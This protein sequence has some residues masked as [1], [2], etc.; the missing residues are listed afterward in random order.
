MIVLARDLMGLLDS[1]IFQLT[2]QQHYCPI[3]N[4][5]ERLQLRAVEIIKIK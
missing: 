4:C 1:Y 3:E 5:L 2:K